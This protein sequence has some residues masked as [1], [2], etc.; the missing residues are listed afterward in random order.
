MEK[1]GFFGG[2]FNPPTYAHL[3]IAKRALKE[4][5]LNKV[6]FVPV[7]NYYN[8]PELEDEKARFYML[9]LMCKGESNIEVEDIE[10]NIKKRMTA[11]DAFKKIDNKYKKTENY[12]IMGADNFVKTPGWNDSMNLLKNY[13]IIVF[14]RGK[15]NIKSEEENIRILKIEKYKDCRSGIIRELAKKGEYEKM[16]SYTKN[17]IVNYIKENGVYNF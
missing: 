1:Y 2:S 17:D 7:G 8:K 3:E 10:L 4:V 11:I 13:N 12:F 14:N 9:N 15:L 6:F 16:K 5:G